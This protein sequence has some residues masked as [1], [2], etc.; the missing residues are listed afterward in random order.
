MLKR[1]VYVIVL[2]C[3]SWNTRALI[4]CSRIGACMYEYM[5]VCKKYLLLLLLLLL[6]SCKS[7]YKD[8]KDEIKI[9]IS[10]FIINPS[11]LITSNWR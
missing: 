7:A 11:N 4:L 2:R 1:T 9:P 3:K 10:D 8:A 6:N 5:C